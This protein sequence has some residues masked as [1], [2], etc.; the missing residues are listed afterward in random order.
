MYITQMAE[1]NARLKLYIIK[2]VKCRNK[3]SLKNFIKL[4]ST[5]ASG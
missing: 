1:A 2:D 5:S 4:K 3:F